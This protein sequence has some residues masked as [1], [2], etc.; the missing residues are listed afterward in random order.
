MDLM[1][2]KKKKRTHMKFGGKSRGRTG[3]KLGGEGMVGLITT[4]Y[5]HVRNSQTIKKGLVIVVKGNNKT[6][7]I[8]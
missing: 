4:H 5:I 6:F 7:K 1:G 3:E 8:N 2:L